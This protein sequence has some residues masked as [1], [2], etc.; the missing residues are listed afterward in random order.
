MRPTL[1]AMERL[2]ISSWPARETRDVSGWLWR[3]SSGGSIRANS[4]STLAYTG[5]DIDAAIAECERLYR[6]RGEPVRFNI[7]EICAPVDLDARLTARGYGLS[8]PC[9]TLSKPIASPSQ[10]PG[11]VEVT[12]APTS[13]WLEVYLAAISASRRPV[14]QSIVERVPG[15]RAFF[16]CRRSGRVIATGLS[17]ADGPLAVVMC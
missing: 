1:L 4:V 3:S 7:S 17:V 9:T 12:A 10:P 5:R 13:E 14:A 6:D 16:A 11:D 15:P 2:A 8:D